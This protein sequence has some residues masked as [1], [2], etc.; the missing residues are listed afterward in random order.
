MIKVLIRKKPDRNTFTLY[1]R[2]PDTKKEVTRT[3]KA[4]NVREAERDASKWEEELIAF[5][6]SDGAG[7]DH[8]R[9][10]FR[11]EHLSTLSEDGRSSYI[12]AL[13]SF[14][15]LM[16]PRSV[17]AVSASHLS[18]Y[19]SLLL[20]GDDAI[21][22]T[23]VASY[24]THL[25]GAFNWA[26]MV[27]MMRD[28]PQTMLPKIGRRRMHRGRPITDAEFATLLDAVDLRVRK[29]QGQWKRFLWLLWLTGLRCGEAIK[30]SWD[31]PP[32]QVCMDTKPYPTILFYL[33]GQKSRVDEA[34]PMTPDFYEWLK[35]IPPIE[36]HGPVA[37][38]FTENGRRFSP[39][40]IGLKLSEI[41]E[42]SGIETTNGS[43]VTAHDLRRSFGTKWAMKVRPMTLQKLMRHS[44]IETTLKYYIG[45]SAADA[46]S[47]VWGFVPNFVP[48]EQHFR[49]IAE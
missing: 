27:G 26:K 10:R 4:A 38:L 15:R 24:L 49:V 46:G 41:G 21:A 12:T 11:G 16:K 45:L 17:A 43:F 44:T 18:E 2:D 13:N 47:D 22:I 35:K 39:K 25:N 33:E 23:S 36:R 28:V 3:S 9:A 1:Y 14:E 5:R 48:S 19:K 42:R 20:T 34:I 8:F 7:W 29:D 31:K 37:P 30:I 40:K 32:V 6:G